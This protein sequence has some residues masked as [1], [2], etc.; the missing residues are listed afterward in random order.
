MNPKL[1][2]KIY[3]TAARLPEGWDT[4]ALKNIFLSGSY[5]AVL[6]KAS[7]V[8]MEC[9]FIG[10]FK[11][12][13]LC[14]IAV[15][16]YID[17]SRINTFGENEKKR[18]SVKDYLF[19]KFSSHILIL[20]NNKLTGQNTY[21]LNDCITEKE[22]LSLFK[23]VLK[24][25]K[26]NYRKKGITISLKAIKDFNRQ[27]MPDFKS[28]GFKE[29]YTFCT[30]PNMIFTIKEHWKSIDDY[31]LDLNKKYRTQYNRARKKAEGIE[32][33]KLTEENIKQ[34]EERI[35]ELYLTVAQNASFNT[36][37]LPKGHFYTFKKE[38]KDNFL[39]YGYFFK[40]ELIGFSTLIKNNSD[41]DTY[42]LG[43]DENVQKEKMLYLNMLYDMVAYAIK[44]QFS[45]VIFARSA[46][47]IKSSVGAKAEEVYG[48]IKHTNPVL[49]LFM[50]RLFPY[51]D[52]KIEWKERNPFK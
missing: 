18:F 8:N 15:A 40:D 17:L 6:E 25:L 41:M 38:L 52:P 13:E 28:A 10:L 23:K 16:Q 11:N 12:E 43:Y 35:H 5:L 36:F 51:F 30:Q 9:H 50:T 3:N 24:E 42:F 20:G 34:Y 4:I 49:N 45:H 33:R 44:K 46:M 2:F 48:I 1:S 31:F 7:P 22:A 19:K 26:K 14:G 47:E 29:Y 37:F 39:F 32:K 21:L 27:E